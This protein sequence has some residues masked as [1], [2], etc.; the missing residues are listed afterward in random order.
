MKMEKENKKMYKDTFDEVHASENLL[1]KVKDMKRENISRIKRISKKAVCTAAALAVVGFIST[2]AVVY[3]AT[4]STWLHKIKVSIDGKEYEAKVTKIDE[5]AVEVEITGDED[6]PFSVSAEGDGSNLEE[7]KF[8]ICDESNGVCLGF[9]NDRLYLLSEEDKID[10]T[11]NFDGGKCEG[12]ME[13][14]DKVYHY[15]VTEDGGVYGL[16]MEE[17]K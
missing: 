4:G 2:N 16:N 3:A 5:N 12:D 8:V 13:I 10:I 14:G 9:E 15:V 11:D 17:K 7:S 6:M 1:R